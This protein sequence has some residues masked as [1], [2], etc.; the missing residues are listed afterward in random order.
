[1]KLPGNMVPIKIFKMSKYVKSEL[2]N[3]LLTK[4]DFICFVIAF[5]FVE[6]ML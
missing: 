2:V 5:V 3:S 1:M 6:V 4:L